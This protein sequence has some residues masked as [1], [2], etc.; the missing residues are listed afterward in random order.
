MKKNKEY[1]KFIHKVKAVPDCYP[2][3]KV[4]ITI[5]AHCTLSEILEKFEDFLRGSGYF[6]KGNITISEEN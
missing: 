4:E 5:D 3:S 2:S 6:F 1:I